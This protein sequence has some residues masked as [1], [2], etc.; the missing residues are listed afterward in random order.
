M[1]IQP[2]GVPRETILMLWLKQP[3][4]L[5]LIHKTAAHSDGPSCPKLLNSVDV[6]GATLKFQNRYFRASGCNRSHAYISKLHLVRLIL[7]RPSAS[8]VVTCSRQDCPRSVVGHRAECFSLR[9]NPRK[10]LRR[11]RFDNPCASIIFVQRE[12]IYIDCLFS[13]LSAF[14]GLST[15]LVR[16]LILLVRLFLLPKYSIIQRQPNFNS[17]KI[18]QRTGKAC[19]C[20][21]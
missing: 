11:R 5:S 15:S 1:C 17:V 18:L 13:L 9:C 6:F 2:P 7:S 14:E 10:T 19:D 3:Y 21:L 12:N 4:T 20:Q 8:T 16:L